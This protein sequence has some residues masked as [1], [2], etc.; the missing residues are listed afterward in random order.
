MAQMAAQRLAMKQRMTDSEK[1]RLEQESE[2]MKGDPDVMAAATAYKSALAALADNLKA[3]SEAGA[4]TEKLQAQEKD[5]TTACSK[6]RNAATLI[7]SAAEMKRF[8]QN[9]PNLGNEGETAAAREKY[10]EAINKL[11]DFYTENAKNPPDTPRGLPPELQSQENALRLARDQARTE[12]EYQSSAAGIKANYERFADA[13]EVK[14]AADALLEKMAA[15]RDAQNKAAEA[16]DAMLK[17]M[18]ARMQAEAAFAAACER[19]RAAAEQRAAAQ[20]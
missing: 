13:P 5:L 2:R 14:T 7:R 18:Q 8:A 1:A 3:Q 4:D 12:Y 16:Q 11:V 9:L 15:L 17:A 20:R 19:N 10:V 6:A